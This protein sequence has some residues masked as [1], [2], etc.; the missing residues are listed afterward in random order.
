[1]KLK[2]ILLETPEEDNTSLPAD[3]VP[4]QTYNASGN[5]LLSKFTNDWM[6]HPK[7]KD[8]GSLVHRA[9][10]NLENARV[11]A[12]PVSKLLASQYWID[13]TGEQ[14][15]EPVF[16]EL[17][18]QQELP[19]VVKYNGQFIILDGHHRADAAT[20]QNKMHLSCWVIDI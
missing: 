8:V 20:K 3:A 6:G 18:E 17:D 10:Q 15:G 7:F 12:V 19:V 5:L 11:A 9:E 2:D 4:L 1:M 13:E 16:P 14:S